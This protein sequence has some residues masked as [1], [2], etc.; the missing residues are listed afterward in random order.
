MSRYRSMLNRLELK[1]VY[2]N[3]RRYTWSNERQLATL[4]KIDHVLSTNDWDDLHPSRFLG[5]V[6][7]A[8]SDHCPLFLELNA[9]WRVDRRFRFEAFWPKVDG[10][11][12]TVQAAWGSVPSMCT[13]AKQRAHACHLPQRPSVNTS[14]AAGTYN[15]IRS[16]HHAPGTP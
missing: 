16:V 15:Q 12:E 1:E 5:A 13:Q 8:I 2:L 9:D 10:F 11:M 4:E 3:G 6:G 7:S 14:W